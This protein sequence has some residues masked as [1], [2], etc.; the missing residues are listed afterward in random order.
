MAAAFDVG[1]AI[2]PALVEAQIEGG[3]VQGLSSALLEILQLE[4]GR[5]L[6]ASFVDYRIATAVDAPRQIIGRYVEVPQDDGPW[7]A[8]GVGEHTMVAVAPAVANALYDA[9]GIRFNDLP[10]TAEK[11]YLALEQ[12]AKT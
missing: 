4:G 6:N 8:R 1:K 2:N 12:D 7:G 5:P 11:V 9:L 3:V 10:L